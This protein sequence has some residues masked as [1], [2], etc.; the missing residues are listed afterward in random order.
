MAAKKSK[1][2]ASKKRAIKTGDPAQSER[3]VKMAQELG[4]DESGD[5]FERALDVL[6]PKKPA[7]KK[8]TT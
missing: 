6:V 4:A 8:K 5:A 3:F 2:S 1:P 7:V